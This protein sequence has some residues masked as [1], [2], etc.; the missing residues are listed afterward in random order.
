MWNSRK[1]KAYK[2]DLG[3]DVIGCGT[4]GKTVYLSEPQFPRP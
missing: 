2:P 4:L 1:G 3:S